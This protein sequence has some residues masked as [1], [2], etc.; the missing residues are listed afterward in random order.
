MPITAVIDT[1]V[2]VSSFLSDKESPP[3]RIINEIFNGTIVPM[4]NDYLLDEYRSVLSREKFGFKKENVHFLLKSIME[5][6]IRIETVSTVIKL[7]DMKDVPIFE[8][9]LATRSMNT[10]LITGNI[11]HFPKSDYV[12]TPKEMLD[13]VGID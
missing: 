1:N 12:V 7:D 10:Y 2:L 3:S 13:I 8:I 4:F 11:R 6:G 9:V 5:Y